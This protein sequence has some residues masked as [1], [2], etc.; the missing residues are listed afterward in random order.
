MPIEDRQTALEPMRLATRIDDELQGNVVGRAAVCEHGLRADGAAVLGNYRVL[1]CC[2]LTKH[3]SRFWRAT[4]RHDDC[5][6]VGRQNTEISI[7]VDVDGFITLCGYGWCLP[8][9]RCLRGRWNCDERDYDQ[10]RRC[11]HGGDDLVGHS[12]CDNAV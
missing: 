6:V 5:S 8:R 12:N 9:P 7:S 10:D 3:F 4:L 11:L 2:L 1:E